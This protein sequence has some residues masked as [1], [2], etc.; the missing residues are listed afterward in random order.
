MVTPEERDWMWNHYCY[1][2]EAKQNMGIRLRLA[3]LMGASRRRQEL[4]NTMLFTMPGTPVLYYGDEIG[5]GDNVY[6]NDRDGVR[7]PMQWGPTLNAGFSTATPQSLYLPV[8][9]DPEF[10]YDT[11]NVQVQEKRARSMLQWMRRMIRVR[12]QYKCFGRGTMRFIEPE[13]TAV[14]AYLREY[15]DE[16]VLVVCNLSSRALSVCLDLPQYEGYRTREI[17]GGSDF[18]KV[19]NGYLLTLSAWGTYLLEIRK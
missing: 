19:S 3:R 18:P 15:G 9:T 2:P 4:M 10:H 12:K 13:D 8:I 17:L 11:I 14:L 5:M 1:V 16:V 6:L 7:T